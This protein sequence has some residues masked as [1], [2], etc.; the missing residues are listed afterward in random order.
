MNKIRRNTTSLRFVRE[1]CEGD[2]AV[3]LSDEIEVFY[4]T[5]EQKI[6]RASLCCR[7]PKIEVGV[8]LH[9]PGKAK[10]TKAVYPTKSSIRG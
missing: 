2:G 1:T 6:V 8:V 10:A 9:C 5:V 4:S 3:E 7:F